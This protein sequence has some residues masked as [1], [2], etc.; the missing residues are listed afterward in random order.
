MYWKSQVKNFETGIYNLPGK[1]KRPWE[2]ALLDPAGNEVASATLSGCWP[3]DTNQLSLDYNDGAGRIT[4]NQNFSA[5]NCSFR[6][7]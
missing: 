1:Y 3:A 4:F 5:D 2:I 7:A 6:S